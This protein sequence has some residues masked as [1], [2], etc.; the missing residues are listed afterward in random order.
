M[1]HFAKLSENNI[2]LNVIVVADS[3]APTEAKG[4]AFLRK[5]Y[6]NTDTWIQTS[7]N[8]YGGVHATDGTPLRKN[9]AG[10]GYTYNADEDAFISPKPY[11]S[12]TLNK[13][14]F[15]WEAPV[16]YPTDGNLYEWKEDTKEWV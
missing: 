8:T 2:V 13:T 12:W 6:N 14:T 16:T 9:Y 7:Y 15:L 1:A 10:I 11:D 3:D 5:L 4:K